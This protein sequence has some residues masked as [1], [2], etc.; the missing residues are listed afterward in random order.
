ML[1]SSRQR[2]PRTPQPRHRPVRHPGRGRSAHSGWWLCSRLVESPCPAGSRCRNRAVRGQCGADVSV[3]GRSDHGPERARW[4]GE[5]GAVQKPA[6]RAAKKAANATAPSMMRPSGIQGCSKM[7]PSPRSRC[8]SAMEPSHGG[9]SPGGVRWSDMASPRSGCAGSLRAGRPTINLGRSARAAR[10]ASNVQ[11]FRYTA[12]YSPTP[13]A[14]RTA[15]PLTPSRPSPYRS[16]LPGPGRTAPVTTACRPPDRRQCSG[17]VPHRRCRPH[18]KAARSRAS[19]GA[20]RSRNCRPC[21]LASG[22]WE[23][24]GG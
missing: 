23:G 2:R 20:A 1:S 18:T 7:P 21:S 5:L 24:A 4:F 15:L 3:P 11:R 10:P 6:I 22:Q 14:T 13:P 19:A 16:R 8:A 17:C 12:P 9:V